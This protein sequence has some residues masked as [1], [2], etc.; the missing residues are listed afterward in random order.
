MGILVGKSWMTWRTWLAGYFLVAL[1]A[2]CSQGPD[3]QG[4][5]YFDYEKTR[6]TEFPNPQYESARQLIADV[7]PR[8]GSVNVDGSSVVLG[9]AV[10]KVQ[11]I[12]DDNGLKCDERGVVSELSLFLEEGRLVIKTH[13]DAPVTAVFSRIK[14]DPYAIYGIDANAK[15]VIEETAP[16]E[17]V[18]EPVPDPMVSKWVGYA[19][20]RSFNA[21][22]DPES[23]RTEG[24][25][26][27]VKVVLNYAEPQGEGDAM[28]KA[29]SSVQVLTFDCP[30]SNYRLDRYVQYSEANGL[31]AVVAD[32]GVYAD[33]K[34]EMKPVPQ[35]S[36]NKVLY[37]RVC[38]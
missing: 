8:Y 31:G 26:T 25:Y 4:A 32:S 27:A 29:L 7:E 9:G 16:R 35:N 6:L 12:N 14:Q 38:R 24:R 15:E 13:G 33:D 36:V 34:A 5:W 19:R 23:I 1:L 18:A 30:G 10:C 37:M 11:K 20:T 21:F 2:G 3:I 17:K 22:Y 28:R